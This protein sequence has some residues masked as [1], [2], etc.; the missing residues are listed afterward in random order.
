M[1]SHKLAFAHTEQ[2]YDTFH[3][4]PQLATGKNERYFDNA[5]KT[6]AGGRKSRQYRNNIARQAKQEGTMAK[7]CSFTLHKAQKELPSL[8]EG[9]DFDA[10]PLPKRS[11]EE[12]ALNTL[13]NWLM[14]HGTRRLRP[15]VSHWRKKP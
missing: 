6:L 4:Q 9:I 13:R 10:L 2:E 3:Q 8:L 5:V 15:K 12:E 14:P 1:A 7:I 11:Q